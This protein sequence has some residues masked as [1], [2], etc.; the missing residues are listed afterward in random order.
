MT[1]LLA[2][3]AKDLKASLIKIINE[4]FQTVLKQMITEKASA[5]K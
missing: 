5:K 3:S 4:Q 1:E 2:L